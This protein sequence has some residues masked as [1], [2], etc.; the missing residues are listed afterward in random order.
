MTRSLSSAKGKRTTALHT[1]AAVLIQDY[2]DK[3]TV[4]S[5]N[6]I[7]TEAKNVLEKQLAKLT[8]K[9]IKLGTIASSWDG[10][11]LK[12]ALKAKVVD[13]FIILLK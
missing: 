5:P 7:N 6:V 4:L 12:K 2:L 8:E 13:E 11:A 3:L 1:I 9:K 10:A